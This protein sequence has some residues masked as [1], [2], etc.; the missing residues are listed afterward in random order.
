MFLINIKYSKT[1]QSRDLHSWPRK[2]FPLLI[3]KF[4]SDFILG[5]HIIGYCYSYVSLLY[6]VLICVLWY[7]VLLCAFLQLEACK[8]SIYLEWLLFI[9]FLH[10]CSLYSLQ[11]LV[12]FIVNTDPIPFGDAMPMRNCCLWLHLVLEKN[13][14]HSISRFMLLCF[15]KP[16][17]IAFVCWLWQQ[18]Y[19]RPGSGNQQLK[20]G[21]PA[22][23]FT[24]M[25]TSSC[26]V[27]E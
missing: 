23:V 19:G 5:A 21:Q 13:A 10:C 6:Y 27:N 8:N 14:Y 16:W 24:R 22:Q 25:F 9:L 3:W 4:H 20:L 17:N 7:D 26:A 2:K 1:K 18:V 11:V 12:F 15:I